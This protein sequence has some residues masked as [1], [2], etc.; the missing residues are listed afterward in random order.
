[1]REFT[2]DHSSVLIVTVLLVSMVVAVEVGHWMG[3]R[4]QKSATEPSRGHVNAIQ[5]S[6]LGIL[7]LLL[8]FTFSLALQRYDARSEAVVD[9]ANAIGTAWLR[10]Q[11]LPEPFRHD[12]RQ[13]MREYL[14]LRVAAS[15]VNLAQRARRAELVGQT[16]QKIGDLWTLARQAAE[17]EPNPVTTGLFVQALNDMIDSFGRR[18]AALERHVP[19]MVL[20][21]LYGTFVVTGG[22]VGF[23]AGIAGHRPSSVTYV[24]V[25]LIVL[26]VFIIID[27]DRPRRGLIDVSQKPLTDLQDAVRVEPD[28]PPRFATTTRAAP[29]SARP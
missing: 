3:R 23:A 15:S 14:D 1:M 9:E 19:E 5:G 28:P 26:L 2:Y 20:F 13:R 11:L 18:D 4:A 25:V 17:R 27:L 29:D 12:V 7:A 10:T 24:M 6:L 22:I 16:Q 8:G 21:L